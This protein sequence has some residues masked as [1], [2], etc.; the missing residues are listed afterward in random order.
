MPELSYW[1]NALKPCECRAVVT[2]REIGQISAIRF[3]KHMAE[4]SPDNIYIGFAE[5][6]KSAILRAENCRSVTFFSSGGGEEL[7][8][9]AKKSEANL[10]A[11]DMD[12]LD[13]YERLSAVMRQ[14]QNWVLRLLEAT[15][16]RNDIH[17]IVNAAS[18]LADMPLILLNSSLRVIYCSA[19]HGVYDPIAEELF[20]DRVLSEE[21][22]ARLLEDGQ[23]ERK[24]NPAPIL[25][26]L[27]NGN[28]CWIQRVYKDNKI[29]STML[30]FSPP[31]RE[32]F[33]AATI[34]E[35]TRT[36]ISRIMQ[37]PA[38]RV[39]GLKPTSKLCSM[40]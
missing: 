31:D 12:I 3:V 39:T 14:Y 18:E 29:I 13:I 8:E 37:I 20:R 9:L 34:L 30:L 33:D 16:I 28:L 19:S 15:N 7:L 1:I 35:L 17:D 21:A 26:R 10:V 5:E 4:P 22:A 24:P 32:D 23:S 36:S 38:E 25:K 11:A 2:K 27:E 40:I 6:V